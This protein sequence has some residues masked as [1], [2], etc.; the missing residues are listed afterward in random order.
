MEEGDC[1][2]RVRWSVW[3]SI[4]SLCCQFISEKG[5]YHG[6][7][8]RRVYPFQTDKLPEGRADIFL[9]WMEWNI[10]I[11]TRNS[12][13]VN[14]RKSPRITIGHPKILLLQHEMWNVLL[15]LGECTACSILYLLVYILNEIPLLIH[16]FG[17]F[18]ISKSD[19]GYRRSGKIFFFWPHHIRQDPVENSSCPSQ[20]CLGHTKRRIRGLSLFASLDSFLPLFKQ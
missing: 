19:P 17:L 10:S 20:C 9:Q 13:L 14:P 3:Q 4:L 12:L 16:P 15:N 6:E 5:T 2:G 11:M 18:A 1:Q 7:Q 8:W